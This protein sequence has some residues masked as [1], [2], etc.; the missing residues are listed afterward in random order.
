M[1]R[2]DA[3]TAAYADQNA[4]LIDWLDGLPPPAWER[5]SRLPGWT[6]RELAF[7]ATDLTAI[8]V[9]ALAGGGSKQAPLS[10]AQYTAAWRPAAEEIAA[11]DR[12]AA[13]DVNPPAVIAN[14]RRAR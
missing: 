14:A 11:R 3:L 5:P 1:A 8:V 6:V 13:S 10:I 4:A 7:H 12:A 2:L 9:R